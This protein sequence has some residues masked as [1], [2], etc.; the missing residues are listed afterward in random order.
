MVANFQLVFRLLVKINLIPKNYFQE[1]A[2]CFLWAQ[3]ILK[4]KA[5]ETSMGMPAA[6]QS[7]PVPEHTLSCGERKQNL[8]LRSGREGLQQG[9]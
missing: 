7:A 8:G 3:E 9:P 1:S 5:W 2:F 6:G 4:V